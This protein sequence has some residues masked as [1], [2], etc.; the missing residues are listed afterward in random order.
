LSNFHVDCYVLS[1]EGEEGMLK[2]I[3]IS[4]LGLIVILGMSSYASAYTISIDLGPT[5]VITS[6]SVPTNPSIMLSFS[7]DD[8]NGIPLDGESITLDILF[9][10]DKFIRIFT[11]SPQIDLGLVFDTNAGGY[12]GFF[13]PGTG[14]LID[15]NGNYFGAGAFGRATSSSGEIIGGLFP[16]MTSGGSSTGE[17]D[18]R[19]YNFYGVHYE[20]SLPVNA[21]V[22]VTSAE[23]NV[24][25]SSSTQIFGV[26]PNI[27]TDV[28]PEPATML[29]L[30]LGLIGLA[31]VRRKM[32]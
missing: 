12:P 2:R 11:S 17:L 10:N 1:K 19:P 28:V 7:L 16:G 18:A 25:M 31:G 15:E 21:G 13:G 6:G 24:Y 26:G 3:W 30:G 9:S 22:V 8:F 27:P 29:L 20:F 4:L 5:G 14:C 32:Q 23:F